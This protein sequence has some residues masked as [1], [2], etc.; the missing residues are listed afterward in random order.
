M[1]NGNS[2]K[3]L[4]QARCAAT[5]NKPAHCV[6]SRDPCCLCCRAERRRHA[7]STVARMLSDRRFRR[8]RRP[9]GSAVRAPTRGMSASS[10]SINGLPAAEINP[11]LRRAHAGNGLT[12][13]ASRASCA[14]SQR[15][16]LFATISMRR[17][18]ATGASMFM[19]AGR[20]FWP[21]R[22]PVSRHTSDCLFKW[23]R[24]G[25]EDFGPEQEIIP[26]HSKKWSRM[27]VAKTCASWLSDL[28]S[29]TPRRCQ[30]ACSGSCCCMFKVLPDSFPWH[31]S[32][33]TRQDTFC[34]CRRQTEAKGRYEQQTH[35]K[36]HEWRQT[37]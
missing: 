15:G 32:G 23:Q 5:A 3:E 9:S 13:V 22:P 11:R 16:K 35:V 12:M 24:P 33:S 1:A 14:S 18:S 7:V 17:A 21:T 25:C 31:I 29:Q 6:T 34:A 2:R 37:V 27:Q 30:A 4:A 19:S 20:T 28:S 8:Q 26:R 36:L 10:C